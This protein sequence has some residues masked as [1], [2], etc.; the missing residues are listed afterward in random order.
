MPPETEPALPTDPT[1]AEVLGE[2]M[3]REPIFHRP[4][5]GT[6]REALERMTHPDFHE[7]GASGK[8]YTRDSV[9]N[10]LEE[11]YKHPAE[12]IWETSNF[13]CRQLAPNLYLL[14]YNLL[15]N[16]I[17]K[18]RRTTLWQRTPT[19]WQIVFHQGTILQEA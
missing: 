9:L 7:I 1:L 18:T 16:H 19:G 10:T 14:N 12:D 8:I 3:Q 4:E 2:L 11:R 6:S 17:R 13:H 15:Q 5:L